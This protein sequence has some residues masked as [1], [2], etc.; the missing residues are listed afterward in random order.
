[1]GENPL[2][3]WCGGFFEDPPPPPRHTLTEVVHG[4]P[5]TAKVVGS[6]TV[7]PRGQERVGPGPPNPQVDHQGTAHL[8]RWSQET[9]YPYDHLLL[10]CG[11]DPEGWLIPRNLPSPTL[12]VDCRGIHHLCR[13]G[14]LSNCLHEGGDGL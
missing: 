4:D 1:M 8:C 2:C 14:S 13:V 9:P 5:H 7:H 6:P 12:G 10:P 3:G 11:G